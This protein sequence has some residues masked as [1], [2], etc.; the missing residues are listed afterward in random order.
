[1]ADIS[2]S[3]SKEHLINKEND[4]SNEIINPSILNTDSETIPKKE[5]N[6]PEQ[7][8]IH[9]KDTSPDTSNPKIFKT[10]QAVIKDKISEET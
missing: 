6:N 1:M 3:Q 2:K 10:K 9:E 7:K 8:K 5:K 4:I